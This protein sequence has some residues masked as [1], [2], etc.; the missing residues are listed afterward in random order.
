MMKKRIEILVIHRLAPPQQRIS[1]R[2]NELG[3]M[4]KMTRMNK[5]ITATDGWPK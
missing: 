3:A 4:G 1:T 2:W 5:T